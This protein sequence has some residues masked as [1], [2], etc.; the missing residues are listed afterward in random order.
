MLR[1][2]AT[3]YCNR[4]V[5]LCTR[6]SRHLQHK[7]KLTFEQ[8]CIERT[9]ILNIRSRDLLTSESMAVAG[10]L[11]PLKTNLF[12]AAGCLTTNKFVCT[13][14]QRGRSGEKARKGHRSSLYY[15]RAR[16]IVQSRPA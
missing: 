10:D 11:T 7:Q 2:G 1:G 8:V 9:L 3:A 6:I 12:T 13:T 5:C 14:E 16:A 15:T 4:V